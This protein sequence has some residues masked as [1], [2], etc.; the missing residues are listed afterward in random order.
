MNSKFLRSTLITIVSLSIAGIIYAGK[1][2]EEQSGYDK[3]KDVGLKAPK[4]AEVLFDGSMKSVKKNWEM[5]PK[6]D[7]EITWE[8]MD[9]PNGDGK[10]LMSAGGKSWGSHDL[11]TKKKYLSLIHI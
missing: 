8:I 11:V 9:N 6:K 3:T 7:M 4:E 2:P 10:T 1:K 5:W